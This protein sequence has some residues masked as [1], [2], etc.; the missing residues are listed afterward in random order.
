MTTNELL[1]RLRQKMQI[2]GD[3]MPKHR[4]QDVDRLRGG[5]QL[6]LDFDRRERQRRVGQG[7]NLT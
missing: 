4:L 3:R 1:T 6:L 7:V 5:E 2:V